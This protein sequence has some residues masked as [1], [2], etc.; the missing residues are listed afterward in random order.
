MK[1]LT[2]AKRILGMDIG[3]NRS[4]GELFLSQ[5]GYMNKVVEKFRMHE[6]KHVTT[7]LRQHDKL[8]IKHDPST[9]EERDRMTPVPFASGVCSIMYGVVCMLTLIMLDIL[10]QTSLYLLE[11][12]PTIGNGSVNNSSL[13]YS[14]HKRLNHLQKYLYVALLYWRYLLELTMVPELVNKEDCEK[15]STL[16]QVMTTKSFITPTIPRFDGHYDHLS[17]LMENFLRSKEFWLV[18]S[19]G[20]NEPELEVDITLTYAKK[21]NST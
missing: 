5:Q 8:S 14:S 10:T 4:K 21:K 11:V 15:A 20:I 16:Q 2:E 1:E 12:C 18:V 7:P 17:M 9:N 13:V 6:S 3:K 19:K